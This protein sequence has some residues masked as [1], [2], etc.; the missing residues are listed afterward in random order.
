MFTNAVE[1]GIEV[2]EGDVLVHALLKVTDGGKTFVRYPHLDG[3]ILHSDQEWQYQH[4]IYRQKLAEHHV[5]QSMSRK[6]NCLNNAMAENF[7]A[8]MKSELLYA[9][10]F[11]SPDDF[12]KALDD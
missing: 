1:T 6:G 7:F 10:N 2:V 12:I 5:T 3:L 9:E 4:S 8:I 11:D